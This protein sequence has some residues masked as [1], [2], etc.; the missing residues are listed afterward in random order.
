M[1]LAGGKLGHFHG[2]LV[3]VDHELEVA[4]LDSGRLVGWVGLRGRRQRIVLLTTWRES[5]HVRREVSTASVAISASAA[6]T[7]TSHGG[8]QAV[9]VEF[10]TGPDED[11][12]AGDE[13]NGE[14]DRRTGLVG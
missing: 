4:D 14:L 7:A 6:A 3:V 9:D 13:W 12:A 10:A 8:F 5:W 2:F 11:L 1:P